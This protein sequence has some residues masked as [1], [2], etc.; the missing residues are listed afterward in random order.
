MPKSSKLRKSNNKA[1]RPKTPDYLSKKRYVLAFNPKTQLFLELIKA[2]GTWTSEAEIIQNV[3]IDYVEKNRN[4]FNSALLDIYEKEF[5][6]E[7]SG[8]TSFRMRTIIEETRQMEENNT[9]EKSDDHDNN[10]KQ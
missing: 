8:P 6:E 7:L 10:N 2:R 4:L 5:L 1:G 9:E 3:I